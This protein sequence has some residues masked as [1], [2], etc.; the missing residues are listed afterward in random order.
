MD[1]EQHNPIAQDPY[2]K[3]V[4]R[5]AKRVA[6]SGVSVLIS[7]ESGVGKEVV[8]RYIHDQSDRA[9][10]EFVAINC[11]AIPDNMLEASLFGYEKGAFT[12]A[13]K[14]HPGKFEQAQNGTL[15]L[16]EI[17]EMPLSLQAKLL[18]VLQEK[19]VERI[20]G[21]KL[22]NLNVRI[23]ATTNR[24][25]QLE[26]AEG[27]F[28]KDLYYRLNIFPIHWVPLRERPL[29]ILPLADY[30]LN[31]NAREMQREKITLSEAAQSRLIQHQ[32]PGNA[33]EMDNVIQ[34]ALIM[35]PGNEITAQDIQLDAYDANFDSTSVT[36]DVSIV[37]VE[38]SDPESTATDDSNPTNKGLKKQESEYILSTLSRH[39]G[40]RTLT[41]QELNISTRTLRY[42]LAKL[43]DQGIEVPDARGSVSGS[44]EG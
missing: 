37:S 34:R 22:I 43:R 26:V 18:R 36:P 4:M 24:N 7:G 19:E 28:R 13:I 21:E 5:L 9:G 23:I 35:Q 33:R 14:S 15:L 32:W 8:A 3:Q 38:K 42:K 30:L 41:A 16:D 17:S 11:A 10:N 39:Q 31:Q 2:S 40:N 6:P 25:M 27:R 1:N 29:D 12:G 44:E 20:G